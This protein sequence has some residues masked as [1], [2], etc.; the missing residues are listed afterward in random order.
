MWD[1]SARKVWEEYLYTAIVHLMSMGDGHP[2]HQQVSEVSMKHRRF[3]VV[4]SVLILQ[5]VSQL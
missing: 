3:N 4:L 1:E 5:K 2:E